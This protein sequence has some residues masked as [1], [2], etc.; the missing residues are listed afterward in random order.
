LG[1]TIQTAIETRQLTVAYAAT[2][3]LWN[4]SLQIPMRRISAI[5]GPNGAGKSTLLKAILGVVPVLSGEVIVN[6]AALVG[7]QSAGGKASRIG[8]VPQ[9]SAVDWDFPITVLDLVLMGTYGRLKW[10]QRPGKKEREDAFEAL[11]QV[12]MREYADRQI[13]QLSGGQQQ[14]VFLARAFVQKAKIYL[15]DEPFAGVDA[16]TE[17]MIVEILHRLRDQ[18]DTIVM[19]H[20]DLTTVANYFDHVTLLNRQLVAAGTTQTTF[21]AENIQAT[22]GIDGMMWGQMSNGHCH[23]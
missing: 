13:G 8:Y 22:Y 5:V 14:R 6:D 20:H 15:L 3:A 16:K 1:E 2:T 19:V 7:E 4:V 9:R 17:K 10:F 23:D 12:Q 21:T 11:E 18:G